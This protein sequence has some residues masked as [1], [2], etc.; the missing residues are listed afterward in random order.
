MVDAKQVLKERGIR[1][2]RLRIKVL[3]V[4]MSS[5][6]SFS[7][8]EMHEYCKKGQDRVTIYRIFNIYYSKGLID[9]AIDTDGLVRYFYCGERHDF[10]PSFRC[11]QCGSIAT[12]SPL[13]DF[14]RK[15]L[16]CHQV[17]DAV[18]LF[19]GICKNC[20]EGGQV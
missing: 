13:P 10:H 20:K 14:Y 5:E 9:K 3:E 7:F 17:D 16:D 15:E 12:L 18:L 11:R 8:T 4:L 1:P 6:K 2:T 19:A